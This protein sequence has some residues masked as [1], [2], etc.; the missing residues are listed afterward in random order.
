MLVA[1]AGL[2]PLARGQVQPGADQPK[3][4]QIEIESKFLEVSEPVAKKLGL[5][6]MAGVPD[7]ES[8]ATAGAK[9]G[10]EP[11]ASSSVMGPAALKNLMAKVDAS[12]GVDLLSAPRVTTRSGQRAVIEVIREYRYATE[13]DPGKNGVI[14]PTAFETRNLGVT[15]EVESRVTDQLIDLQ[16]A[17]QVVELEGFTRMQD[18]QPLPLRSGRSIGANRN[19][20]DL[21]SINLPK[22]TIAQP[23]FS[24]RKVTTRLTLSSGQSV[25]LGGLKRDE[26]A[27]GT[28]SATRIL[29]VLITARIVRNPH[30]ATADEVLPVALIDPAD[31]QGF[32]RSPFA[33]ETKPIDA[34]G[35]PS[36]AELKCPTTRKLFR[37]R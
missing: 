29:Y 26:G 19:L 2:T 9:D 5:L 1:V 14:T 32:V 8:P 30:D 16:L 34:R 12:K 36:G 25:L 23:V 6:P 24:T 31:E 13:F 7:S 21:A 33:P 28:P 11:V 35:L 22:N 37:L 4:T 3:D 15:L 18:G 10:P 17:P 27:E 20:K